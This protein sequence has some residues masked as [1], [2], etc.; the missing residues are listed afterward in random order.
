MVSHNE[1]S[2][3]QYS[4]KYDRRFLFLMDFTDETLFKSSVWVLWKLSSG[5]PMSRDKQRLCTFS[6]P[7]LLHQ[8]TRRYNP[9]ERRLYCPKIG[10]FRSVHSPF[11]FHPSN[12]P[13]T[14]VIKRRRYGSKL[15]L[16]PQ[17]TFSVP[18]LSFQ[19]PRSAPSPFRLS[20]QPSYKP[21]FYH[22]S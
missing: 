17:V 21:K 18:V 13:L 10:T 7:V 9:I 12:I 14:A 8:P 1:Y 4:T 19:H 22:F 6:V 20:N 2:Q 5:I 11:P 16:F 3:N 15:P